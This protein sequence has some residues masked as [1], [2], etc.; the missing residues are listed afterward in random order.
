MYI[1]RGLGQEDLGSLLSS[2]IQQGET[3]G[4]QA[5]I[6]MVAILGLVGWLIYRK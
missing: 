5:L 1:R 4:S 2:T 3:Q 6:V